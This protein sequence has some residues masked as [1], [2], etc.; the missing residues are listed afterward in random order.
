MS[1]TVVT[2][3]KNN[4]TQFDTNDTLRNGFVSIAYDLAPGHPLQDSLAVN[5]S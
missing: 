5:V 2:A 3:I 4:Q 1:N